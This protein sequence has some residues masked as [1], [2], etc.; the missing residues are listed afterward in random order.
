M[1]KGYSSSGFKRKLASLCEPAAYEIGIP[2][3]ERFSFSFWARKIPR[4]ERSKI[5]AAR[6]GRFDFFKPV[7]PMS[8]L[9]R[10]GSK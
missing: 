10:Q 4:H 9:M 7:E 2:M 6:R 3:C 1:Y 5:V 8:D